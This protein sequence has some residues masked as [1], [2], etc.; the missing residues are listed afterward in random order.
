MRPVQDSVCQRHAVRSCQT[1]LWCCSRFC[2]GPVLFTLLCTTALASIITRHNFNHHFLA[3][4]TQLLNSALPENIHTLTKTTPDCYS[5]IKNWMTPN[6]IQLN[7]EKT[8][9][10]LFATRQKLSFIS[11][12]GFR[13]FSVFGRSAC[14]DLP[15]PFQQNS[16][17]DSFKRNR[18][19]FFPANHL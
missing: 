9:A 10:M 6:N 2:P 4:D 14:S 19:T 5:D 16:S 18:E 8:E 12:V 7:G 17:L 15:L 1:L 3:D 11:T 13:A